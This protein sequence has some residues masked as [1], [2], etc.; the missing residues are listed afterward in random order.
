MRSIITRL[1]VCLVVVFFVF[2]LLMK[3]QELPDAP[4][5]QKPIC[6]KKN[7]KPCPRWET[8]LI[9]QYP[10]PKYQERPQ[11]S[12]KQTLASK[13][14]LYSW[15]VAG[16][17][18]ASIIGDERDTLIGESH[19]CLEKGTF[20][21]YHVS[22]GRMGAVDWPIWLGVNTFSVYLRKLKIPIAPYST[23]LVLAAKHSLGM[24]HWY[25]TGC[26]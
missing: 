15:T 25:Q 3:A 18:A 21:G 4:Q 10:P 23:P 26:L 9:G 14:S 19:G 20:G 1:L 6:V 24:A 11:L 22:L 17:S 5:P 8:R 2:V 7:G 12:W 16:V 13:S